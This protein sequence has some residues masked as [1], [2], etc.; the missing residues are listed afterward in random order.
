MDLLCR[1][2]LAIQEWRAQ[3]DAE[4]AVMHAAAVI[5]PSSARAAAQEREESEANER[6]WR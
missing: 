2:K 4:R 1:K 5:A 3:K 6:I